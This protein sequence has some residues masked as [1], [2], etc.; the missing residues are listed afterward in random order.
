MSKVPIAN[1]YYFVFL[2]ACQPAVSWARV[3]AAYISVQEGPYTTLY[4]KSNLR[5]PRKG[6]ARPPSRFLHSY[7]TEQFYKKLGMFFY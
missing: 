6:I 2:T 7:A 5:I 3:W 1:L 4:R